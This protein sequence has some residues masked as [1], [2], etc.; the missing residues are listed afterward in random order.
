MES[1]S[2]R[3]EQRQSEETRLGGELESGVRF[4]EY[5]TAEEVLRV[6]RAGTVPPPGMEQR[7]AGVTRGGGAPGWA[8]WKRWFSR[9]RGPG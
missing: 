3:L 1:N 8:W 9:D 5:A 6:D 4:R 2:K 7:V